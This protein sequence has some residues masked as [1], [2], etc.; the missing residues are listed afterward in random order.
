M[1]I[2]ISRLEDKLII[3][4][5]YSPERIRKIKSIR[6]YSWN[7]DKKEWSVPYTTENISTLR[8]LF[9]NEQIVV[10][11]ICNENNE[12]LFNLVD[13]QLKLKGYS[14]KTRKTYIK[15]L[16]R[17]SSFIAKDLNSINL[18]DVRR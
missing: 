9:R 8:N 5:P 10:D 7:A 15:K 13:E 14:F 1:S 16:K 4:F 3:I 2:K 6:G 18:Q 11:F 17:F 12:R